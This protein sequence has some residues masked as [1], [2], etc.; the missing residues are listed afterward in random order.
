MIVFRLFCPLLATLLLSFPLIAQER[1]HVDPSKSEVHFTLSDPLHSVKGTFRI[2]NGT[3]TFDEQGHMSGIVAVDAASGNSGNTTRDKKMAH[4][5]LKAPTFTSITFEPTGYS[6]NLASSGDSTITV[7]GTFTLLGKTHPIS[8]PM[9]V[10]LSA[11]Q[12]K[13]TGTFVVPY[14]QWGVKDPS[15]FLMHVGK[16]VTVDL[17][18]AGPVT[19]AAH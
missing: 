2:E 3:I 1:L 8:V 6:G 4:D 13:A 18:L 12:C 7:N 14:V 16:D 11:D 5:Q 15:N 19:A 9:K 17:T 10:A